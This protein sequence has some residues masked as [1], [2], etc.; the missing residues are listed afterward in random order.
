[1]WK[2]GWQSQVWSEL[3]QQWDMVII[4]GG[5]TGAGVFHEAAS[6]G[7]K[8]LLVEANDFSFGTSSRSSKL[9]HGGFRYLYN[10]QYAVTYESVRE[11]ERLL[12]EAPQLVEPL[13]FTIPNYWDYHFPS[14]LLHS[15]LVIYDLMAA[16][17]DHQKLSAGETAER[18]PGLRTEGLIKSF[19]YKD[20][21]LDDAR[22]VLRVIK[23]GVMVGGTAIN[24]TKAEKLLTTADGRVHGVLVRDHTGQSDRTVEVRAKVVINATGPWTDSIRSG[25]SVP[26]RMRKLR[27]SHL[28]FSRERLPFNEALTLFHPEDHRAMF[29]IPWEGTTLVGTTDIDHDP[30]LDINFSEPFASVDEI[31][32]MLTA[33]NFLF[34]DL[35]L[36]ERDILS[37]FS[38]LRPIIGTGAAAPSKESRAHQIWNERGLITI[39]G[40]KLTTFR[41][42]ATQTVKAAFSAAGREI[43]PAAN[44]RMINNAEVPPTGQLN[45]ETL[46][47]ICGRYGSEA[48][49]LIS[50]AEK[51]DL[52]HIDKL[53]NL[54]AEM[55]WAARM[56]GV[57]H[58]DDL[59]L[60]RVRIGML[61]PDGGKKIMKQVRSIVQDELGWADARW[62]SEVAAYW[63]T[64]NTY[65]SP[66]PG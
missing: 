12:K 41:L 39:T 16:K 11:R 15:G 17:W 14:Y 22:L 66:S 5:I 25:L 29:V 62:E 36:S 43:N 52:M 18:F 51:E 57:N 65:Y 60:R 23:E 2:N 30:A 48:G 35:K 28:I 20:A 50:T 32:Y 37:T 45:P 1:M 19:R 26:D 44:P 63:Q 40:G 61:L 54:W 55:R 49:R 42:M 33:L 56:E 47:Y 9:V 46:N 13:P 59:L 3:D 24:Y 38:G 34:S 4:G 21:V 8:T 64:W 27:G 10:K 53:P 58:L 7:L 6:L 31:D